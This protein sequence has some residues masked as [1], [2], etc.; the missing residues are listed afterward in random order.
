MKTRYLTLALLI[1]MFGLMSLGGAASAQDGPVR[2]AVI[3]PSSTTDLAW[4]QAMYDSLVS[5]QEALGGESGMEIAVSENTW[6]VT[7]APNDGG[8]WLFKV[9]YNHVI[10]DLRRESGRLRLLG[11]F[12]EDLVEG[13][14]GSREPYT[15]NEIRDDVLR[16]LFVCCDGLVRRS[17]NGIS[18]E[19][20]T[21]EA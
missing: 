19:S 15:D 12:A 20:T 18:L 13:R 14:H 11:R 16:M 21:S 10:Q 3:L 1:L 2:V 8:A 9:A 5:V 6:D 7:A 17:L 4:S